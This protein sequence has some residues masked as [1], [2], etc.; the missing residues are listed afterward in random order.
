MRREPGKLVHGM[1][2]LIRRTG[3]LVLALTMAAGAGGCDGPADPDA[4]SSPS[5]SPAPARASEAL[6]EGRGG[7]ELL[8]SLSGEILLPSGYVIGTIALSGGR[9]EVFLQPPGAGNGDM[10]LNAT[11]TDA[12]ATDIVLSLVDPNDGTVRGALSLAET[13]RGKPA[14]TLTFMGE[15][16]DVIVP[17]I[18]ELEGP[19]DYDIQPGDLADD[20]H[21]APG[22]G[23]TGPT[24]HLHGDDIP[25]GVQLRA[26][27]SGP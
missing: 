8:E 18:A 26:G 9:G 19:I 4:P 12:G 13:A 27:G 3:S 7:E 11:A 1:G 23:V 14:G 20:T 24:H 22:I 5:A 21:D 16:W 10:M 15:K 17:V 6:H 2:G 25:A